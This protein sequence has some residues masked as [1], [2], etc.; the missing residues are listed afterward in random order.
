MR[1]VRWLVLVACAGC[2]YTGAS[3]EGETETLSLRAGADGRLSYCPGG[4]DCV[5]LS[6]PDACETLEVEID[7]ATGSTCERCLEADGVVRSERCEQT[8]VACTLVTAP[9]PDCVVCAHVDGPVIYSSCEPAPPSRCEYFPVIGNGECKRC[10]NAAGDL[11]ADTCAPDCSRIACAA[12]DCAEG[13]VAE[14]PPGQCCPVCLPV[15]ACDDVACPEIALPVCDDGSIPVRDPNDCCGYLCEPTDCRF[16]ACP[17]VEISCPPGTRFDDSFP[18]CCGT[19]VPYEIRLCQDNGDCEAGEVCSDEWVYGETIPGCPAPPVCVCADGSQS[20]DGKCR[21]ACEVVDCAVPPITSCPAG[22]SWTDAFPYCCGGCVDD[23]ESTC[24][25]TGGVWRL[26]CG[27]IRCG[28]VDVDCEQ[29]FEGCDCGPFG[30]W[31]D[32][33]GCVD[34]PTCRG[35]GCEYNTQFYPDGARFYA[36]DG[37][38]YCECFDGNVACTEAA[39]DP[40]WGAVA[41]GTGSC[42]GPYGAAP[43]FCCESKALCG[44]TGGVWDTRSCGD[45]TCG[46]PPSCDA[47][48]PGC[49]CGEHANF[50]IGAGCVEDQNCTAS[51]CSDGGVNYGEGDSWPAPDGCNHCTCFRGEVLCTEIA[52][53]P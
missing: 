6:N 24:A 20:Y 53:S 50:V 49:D 10:Y 7:T 30:A 4:V 12:V 2:T 28:V 31:D 18:N 3:S 13:F 36:D 1:I 25:A 44:S 8:A 33:A 47:V 34:E 27:T 16:V 48:V 35:D 21:D 42:T 5:A 40:C 26:T 45:Y 37:C 23:A 29:P 32:D 52:C 11:T 17:A 51:A 38:N 43:E 15:T 9:E 46:A 22:Q 39:C 19:C 41:T 14:T